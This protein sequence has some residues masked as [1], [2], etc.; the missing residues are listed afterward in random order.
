MQGT[1]KG[2]VPEFT[3][4]GSMEEQMVAMTEA[5]GR[6]LDSDPSA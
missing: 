6:M 3:I 1:T 2:L 5:L 4:K